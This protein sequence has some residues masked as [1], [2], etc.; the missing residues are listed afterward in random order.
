MIIFGERERGD[1]YLFGKSGGFGSEENLNIF[2][3]EVFFVRGYVLF[4]WGLFVKSKYLF[5]F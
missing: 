1:D 3:F 5:S 4:F 2:C